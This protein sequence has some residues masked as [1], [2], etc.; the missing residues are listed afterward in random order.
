MR[1]ELPAILAAALAAC[2]A[3]LEALPPVRQTALE[4]CTS[5]PPLAMAYLA[6]SYINDPEASAWAGGAGQCL[7]ASAYRALPAYV[8]VSSNGTV[9]ELDFHDPCTGKRYEL[10]NAVQECIRA[11]LNSLRVAHAGSACQD[12]GHWGEWTI[13]RRPLPSLIR[14]HNGTARENTVAA[15][16]VGCGGT[17]QLPNNEMHLTAGPSNGVAPGRR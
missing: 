16:D 12:D 13:F 9:E 4:P 1:R 11:A 15:V 8:R 3:G 14:A 17:N 7:N 2:D 5:G 10:E 6:L